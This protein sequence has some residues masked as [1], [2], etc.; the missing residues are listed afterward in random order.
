MA[1]GCHEQHTSMQAIGYKELLDYFSNRVSL[2]EAVNQIKKASRRY[3]KRQLSWFRAEPRI[4]WYHLEEDGMMDVSHLLASV[5]SFWQAKGTQE[6]KA[7][8][9][10]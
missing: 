7:P 2:D 5:S 6:A 4:W 3:A 8:E 1:M 10:R 9:D